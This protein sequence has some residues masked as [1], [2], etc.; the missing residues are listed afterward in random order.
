MVQL[1]RQFRKD[2]FSFDS[3]RGS[4]DTGVASETGLLQKI[5]VYHKLHTVFGVIHQTEDRRRARCQVQNLFQIL[6]LCKG[7]PGASQLAGNFHGGCSPIGMKKLF[8]TTIHESAQN[9]PT[10][11]CSAGKI[12]HQLELSLD[13]LKQVVPFQLADIIAEKAQ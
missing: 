13:S 1:C 4:I 3:N 11:L 10:I 8:H 6:F 2:I 12:G 7:K 9:F 5:F